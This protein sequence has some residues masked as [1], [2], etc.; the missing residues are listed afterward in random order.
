MT[1]QTVNVQISAEER[2]RLPE[3]N[4][5][6]LFIC[7]RQEKGWDEKVL[8]TILRPQYPN[9]TILSIAKSQNPFFRVQ[10]AI[11]EKNFQL[12]VKFLK[13]TL[14]QTHA[15][16]PI[17]LPLNI[18]EPTPGDVLHQINL[19]R[20]FKLI[21]DAGFTIVL[22]HLSPPQNHT[23]F[24]RLLKELR[25][26]LGNHFINQIPPQYHEQITA[27]ISPPISPAELNRFEKAHQIRRFMQSR[28]FAMSGNIPDAIPSFFNN[29]M[30][31]KTISA[32]EGIAE[33][34]DKQAIMAE[35]A[36]LMIREQMI[37][38][39]SNFEVFVAEA[40]QIPN[41]LQEIGRL[42]EQTFRAVGEGTGQ[43][44]D[45][46]EFDLYYRQLIIWDR[47]EGRIVG[48][49][50]IGC[51]DD[52]YRQYGKHGFYISTLFR[53]K[54]GFQPMLPQSLELGRS[55]IVADYQRKPL[56]LFLLWKGILHFVN[57]NPQYKY[58]FGPVSISRQFSDVSRGLMVEFLK[59]HHFDKKFALHLA[60]RKPFKIKKSKV[61]TNLLVDTFGGELTN[62]DK[63]IEGIEPTQT[64]MP[65]LLR[66]YI[67]QNAKFIGFNLDPHFS[68]CL[69]GFMILDLKNLP[70]S[71][72]E[73]LQREKQNAA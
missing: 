58:V 67:R 9:L 50:R 61:D 3:A 10:E 44:L 6:I 66:Q 73:N 57:Q 19:N 21:R 48:G 53:I 33:A 20:F 38:S 54:T 40:A 65:V 45:L 49:Y 43:R 52:I 51:G 35:I 16:S 27:R 2:R 62:L 24:E 56:P 69:D 72:I 22:I 47:T 28:L 1:Q 70:A 63:F 25:K 59:K 64:R 68:D 7:N 14:E 55:Y 29:W 32:V 30:P 5:P 41:A 39:Q 46:D 36:A 23:R 31:Q 37:V 42:R 60:P 71:T 11:A 8:E 4:R 12:L 26:I 34:V 15:H 17:A 13:Q 18:D